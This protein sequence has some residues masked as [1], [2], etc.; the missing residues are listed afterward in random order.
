MNCIPLTQD[1]VPWKKGALENAKGHLIIHMNGVI[2]PSKRVAFRFIHLI[3]FGEFGS[4]YEAI[5]LH[6]NEHCAIKVSTNNTSSKDSAYRENCVLKYI[7]RDKTAPIQYACKY[8]DYF[9]YKDHVFTVTEKLN[10]SVLNIIEQSGYRGISLAKIQKIIRDASIFISYLHKNKMCHGDLKPENIMLGFDGNFKVIDFGGCLIYEEE[11][12][13]TYFQSRYY[14]APE[15][16]LRLPATVKIDIWSLGCIAAELAIGLP[17]IAGTS[18]LHCLQLM[19]T[20]C[21]EIPAYMKSVS[22]H[23]N[24]FFDK[25]SELI[26]KNTMEDPSTLHLEKLSGIIM[27]YRDNHGDSDED[28]LKFIN[29]LGG[30]LCMDPKK[31]FSIEDVCNHEFLHMNF[32]NSEDI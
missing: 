1:P 28:K 29:F 24:D 31:R 7:K 13:N 22:P 6:T 25:N 21:G 17:I 4:V 23:Y 30:M 11:F 2:S 27:T 32:N 5:A 8:V 12:A 15:V 18:E 3:G 16:M 14:R 19:E 10:C 20:R 26:N 9:E